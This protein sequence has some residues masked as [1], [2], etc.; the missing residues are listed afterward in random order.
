M[1][2]IYDTARELTRA[3]DEIVWAVNPKF[4]SLDSLA[5]YLGKFANDYLRAVGIR[6]RLNIP[7]QLPS[8]PLT[9]EVRHN[10]FLAFKE[11]L[12]N[13]VKHAAASEVKVTLDLDSVGF[14]LTVEDNGRGFDPDKLAQE[15]PTQLDRIEHGLGLSNI[16]RRLAEI[17]G[18][19][20]IQSSPGNGTRVKLQV[21]LKHPPRVSG[22]VTAASSSEN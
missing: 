2:R 14:V 5:N 18:A 10:L 21:R 4:D 19:C 3:M 12:H 11:T 7:V 9:S 16:E 20:R 1:E 8:W 13:I 6:C 15:A 17:G 22:L